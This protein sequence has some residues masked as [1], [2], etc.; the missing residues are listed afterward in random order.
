MIAK[1]LSGWSTRL[2]A[3]SPPKD[4]IAGIELEVKCP[5]ESFHQTFTG[6]LTPTLSNGVLTFGTGSGELQ[7]EGE[8]VTSPVIGTD[9]LTGPAGEE[10]ITATSSE[11][12]HWLGSGGT[13]AQGVTCKKSDAGNVWNPEGGDA[14]LDETVLFDL[15]ECRSAQCP[16]GVSVTASGMPWPSELEEAPAGSNV[17]RDRT[18]GITVTINCEGRESVFTG[19]WTPRFR[20]GTAAKPSFE[21]FGEGSGELVSASNEGPSLK[22]TGYDKMVGFEEG[23]EVITAKATKTK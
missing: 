1:N 17:I 8:P 23:D 10:D 13:E 12:P 15:Y 16:K 18:T 6:T 2:I 7:Q 4:E 3:G 11:P 19:E 20:N 5:H 22:I 9:A 14:G 21:E